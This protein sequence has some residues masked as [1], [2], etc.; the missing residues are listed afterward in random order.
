MV[1]VSLLF[2]SLKKFDINFFTG[3]PDSLL[4]SFCAYVTDNTSAN[5][6]I[7]A[8][9]EGAAVGLAAGYHIAT[10][11]IP[12]VY[13]QNS[14]LG[15]AINP[16]LSLAD[17][18]VYSIPMIVMI[19]WRGEPGLKDEPQHVKQ[20]RVQNAL[21][22]AME[23]P[24]IIL[25]SNVVDIDSFVASLVDMAKTNGAPVAL[26]VKSGSFDAYKLIQKEE[27]KFELTREEAI[28][29]ILSCLNGEEVIISTTG[30]TSREVFEL[31]VANGQGNQNDFLTVGSMGHSSQIALGIALNTDRKV[32]C[33]DGDGSVIMHM[34]SLAIIGSSK[35]KNLIHVVF[36]NG[37]HDSVGGQ[38]TVGF[39][40]NLKK[41]AHACGYMNTFSLT[42][43]SDL[44]STFKKIS[45]L[46]GPVFLEIK[47]KKGARANLGRP[48]KS[49]E[50]NK[51]SLMKL[52]K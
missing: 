18:E 50:E 51:K 19:G 2:K 26:V 25:D 37:V 23:I 40:I 22:E 27:N 42:K 5:E 4:K 20:G 45:N 35:V 39:L 12:L 8:A 15:N 9:N 28:S 13:L 10:G 30:F 32:I 1:Q 17:K 34:G 29:N 33:L 6:H 38:A 31:R 24:Y 52:L 14:G 21:L 49:P 41:I 11:K 48:T 7:I 16:L 46:S 47:T 3:V 43:K 36:N 44:I